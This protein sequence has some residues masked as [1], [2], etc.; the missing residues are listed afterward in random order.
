M[1]STVRPELDVG[2]A[3]INRARRS[4]YG[5]GSSLD[6][7]IHLF[8]CVYTIYS[9]LTCWRWAGKINEPVK[10]AVIQRQTYIIYHMRTLT[11]DY[12]SS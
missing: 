3:F 4:F 10:S 7:V 2:M 1:A 5:G 9:S 11:T 12:V 8:F 6:V